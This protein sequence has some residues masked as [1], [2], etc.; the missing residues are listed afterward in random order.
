MKNRIWLLAIAFTVP[1]FI[2]PAHAAS[3]F[4]SPQGDDNAAGGNAAPFRT[5]QK[6]ATIA[7]PGD[8]VLVRA[9]TYRETV[10][11][12]RSGLPGAPIVFAAAPGEK[13]VISGAEPVTGWS[14]ADGKI[15]KANLPGD[16]YQSKHNYA[17]QI[18]VDGAM[19][20]LAR[21]PNTSLD[22]SNPVKS[23]LT[24]FISKTRDKATNWTTAVFEDENLPDGVSFVGA[25][26]FIQPNKDAWSWA[27]SGVITAQNG[28]QL[29][30]RSRSD[31]G[32]DGKQEVY[33]VGSRYYLHNQ[34]QMLDSNGEWFHDRA[35][36]LLYLQTPVGDNPAQ[37]TIEARKRDFAFDL[38]DKSYI[39]I[40]G[41]E[42]F[43]CTI[44]TDPQMGS[45]IEWDAEG[46]DLY[47]WRS[48]DSIPP[49]H[50]IVVDGLNV[51][52]PS[53]FTDMSGHFFLQWGLN[54]G[55]NVSGVNQTIQN[56]RIR[57]SAGNGIACY[58][59]Q[60]KILNNVI[61]DTDYSA[62]DCAAIN[63]TGGAGAFDFEI[64]N[65]TVRRCGRS[66]LS[67][68]GLQNTDATR[69][70]TRVH[71]ND[72]GAF[73]LQDF[74]GGAT[75]TFGQDAKFARVDHNWFHDATGNTVSGFYIDYSKNWI[76][77]HNVIWNVDWAIHLEGAHTSGVV[78]ALV[79]NNTALSRGSSI[80][81]GNGQAPGSY[82]VNNIFNHEIGKA[83]G[84][85]K[86]IKSNLIW[87][88]QPG[89]A[90]DPKFV[91]VSK[92]DFQVKADSPA[93]DASAALT[94]FSAQQPGNPDIIV[95][96]I[97]SEA[98][99]GKADIG[100]YEFGAPSW[101]AG[102]TLGATPRKP[103]T[104]EN[105]SGFAPSANRV[106]LSWATSLESGTGITIERK[107]GKGNF[108]PIAT[109]LLSQSDFFDTKVAPGITYVYRLRAAN[110]AGESP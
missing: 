108:A 75:Y 30:L 14:A 24:K 9:G 91:D 34:K 58:G 89:S 13:V 76:V 98:P 79:F 19:V 71:H 68:R 55:L 66:G 37:H 35:A 39:T 27:L 78:D 21:W 42:L 18:F 63:T 22:V 12:P 88:N 28:K 20:N 23:T 32:Q 29:T 57:F 50:H 15:Y 87:D 17:L 61:E 11:P 74:D 80:G 94:T 31:S 100:A 52:Y 5:L 46:K 77:D 86:E 41:F 7:Q 83:S 85:A 47:L 36:G 43:A 4:V 26:I 103:A 102:S 10:T 51:K 106:N 25:E 96:A 81:I 101:T 110:N 60:N 90:T 49:S 40:Q 84:A 92:S 6:A 95:P 3:Y 67:L 44:T 56:C 16:F 82:Y 8:T 65:N 54:T 109:G 64:A 53:H 93:R 99:D 59:R 107:T 2:V 1:A 33:A 104:P 45:G 97:K 38:A 62:L 48:F 70:V 69:L 72:V 105:L 73:M